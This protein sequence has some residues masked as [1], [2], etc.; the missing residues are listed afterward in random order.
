MATGSWG[1]APCRRGDHASLIVKATYGETHTK[2]EE[3]LQSDQR[4]EP[5]LLVVNKATSAFPLCRV[6]C[7]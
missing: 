3:V 5:I 4:L 2:V 7:G 1:C 6:G